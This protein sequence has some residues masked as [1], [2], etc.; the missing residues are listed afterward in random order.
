MARNR[1]IYQSEALYISPSST[2]YHLQSGQGLVDISS[3]PQP[4]VREFNLNLSNHLAYETGSLRWSGIMDPATG[5]SSGPEAQ[6]SPSGA[7]FRS[8]VE[9]LHRIQSIN[10]DFNINRQDINEFGRLARLDSIV[11]DSPTVNL[12]PTE[13]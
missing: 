10:F 3:G 11:M 8:L 12:S 5:N 13:S 9:P 1:V 7:T 2:G 4:P 6:I